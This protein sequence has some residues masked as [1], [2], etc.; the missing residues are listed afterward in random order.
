MRYVAVIGLWS[1]VSSAAIGQSSRLALTPSTLGAPV[2][3][4]SWS[5]RQANAAAAGEKSP[6][7]A[8]WLSYAFAGAGSFYAGD[9]SHGRR[10]LAI[11]L[12][13]AAAV[14]GGAVARD[15]T[16][17]DGDP[18][19]YIHPATGIGLLAYLANG[20]W[21]GI[22]AA[23]DAGRHNRSGRVSV[24]VDPSLSRLSVERPYPGRTP[25]SGIG[26]RLLRIQF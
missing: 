17:S 19:Q 15:K 20:V 1:V 25:R 4:G 16:D 5:G 23:G 14:I 26:L 21:G 7:L 11:G 8:A 18:V 10:H 12:A 6:V 9:A 24:H 13:A 22:T 3:L 2:E